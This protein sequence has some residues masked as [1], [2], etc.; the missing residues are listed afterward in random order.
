MQS[1][2][3]SL[4][5]FDKSFDLLTTELICPSTKNE[6]LKSLKFS[7]DGSTLLTTSESN[8]VGLWS[9]DANLCNELSYYPRNDERNPTT[10]NNLSL[11]TAIAI[12]D[13]IYDTAWYPLMN[14][15]DD[16][17]CCFVTTS[18]DHPVHLWDCKTGYT[19]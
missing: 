17:T 4:L 8:Y 18:R 15:Q 11:S 14:K 12:G 9:L 6:F 19:R 5:R 16:I 3:K 13:S 2:Y 7:P 1:S 10:E